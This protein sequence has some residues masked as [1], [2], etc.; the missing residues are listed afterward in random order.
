MEPL[1]RE[2]ADELRRLLDRQSEPVCAAL[3][4][5]TIIDADF[6]SGFVTL[7]FAPQPAFRNHFGNIQGGFAVAMLDTVVSIAAYARLR[8]W[9]P[10]VEIKSS[11]LEPIPIGTC[12]GEGR[13][14]KVGR[15]LAFIE[16][17][18]LTPDHRPAVTATATALV[19][20]S[21]PGTERAGSEVAARYACKPGRVGPKK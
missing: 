10:T 8:R 11:F 16:G 5:F 3:T 4:P 21:T 1:M 14:L 12:I 7:E 15:S 17:R 20:T 13:V 9:L 18:L 19:P 2:T 6:E